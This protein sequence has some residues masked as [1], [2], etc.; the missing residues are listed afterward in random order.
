MDQQNG[1]FI[2]FSSTFLNTV[3]LDGM[4]WYKIKHFI[5]STI[6]SGKMDIRIV[7]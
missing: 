5:E 3:E 4:E 1:A 6:L 7:W 2:N